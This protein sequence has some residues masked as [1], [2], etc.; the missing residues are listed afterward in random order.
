MSLYRVPILTDGASH[1]AA[2]FRMLIRD[3]A[4][5]A[6]GITEGDDLKV[7]QRATPGAGITVADGSCV[8]KGRDDAFQGHYSAYN[9]GS[10]NVDIAP[11]GSGSGRSDMVIVRV[12]DP[13]YIAGLNPETD[14]IVFFEVISNVSSSAIG[15]PDGR[16]GIPLARI[17]L[18][19]ST[20]TITDA[21]ITDLRKIA[22]P[23]RER[24]LLPPQ[25]PP[26]MSSQ[27]G[28]TSGTY[29]YFSTASGWFISIPDWATTCKIRLDISG[30]RLVTGN[31]YGYLR[32]TFGGSLTMQPVVIDDN[33]GTGI[34]RIQG[35]VGA[36]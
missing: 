8:I 1:P 23:R 4:R 16:T 7:T 21:M 17:D 9:A 26:S 29:S 11:T 36:G 19:A 27:I 12:Q 34:R 24:N 28:G 33:Q 31:V 3:L 20:A 13:E 25:S 35:R 22:N 5:G 15:I 6:E 14:Q 32:A 18:P 2:Q 10:F 30:L